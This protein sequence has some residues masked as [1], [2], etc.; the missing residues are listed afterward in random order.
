MRRPPVE[1]A[2]I[3]PDPIPEP[4]RLLDVLGGMLGDTASAT[5][6]VR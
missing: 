2:E 5:V 6:P 1:L 4:D 3:D